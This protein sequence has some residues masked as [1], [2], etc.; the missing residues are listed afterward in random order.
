LHRGVLLPALLAKL[1]QR[2]R[3]DMRPAS[4]SALRDLVR[5]LDKLGRKVD[6]R[7]A[8]GTWHGARCR[9]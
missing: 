3:D 7:N 6:G 8:L 2:L 1:P 4:I 5:L 9:Y